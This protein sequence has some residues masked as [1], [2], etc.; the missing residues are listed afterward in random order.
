[1]WT[2]L[3]HACPTCGT[4]YEGS[5]KF[6]AE[7]GTRLGG[8]AAC[9]PARGA[10]GLSTGNPSPTAMSLGEPAAWDARPRAVRSANRSPCCSPTS[11]ASPR[12]SEAR[13]AEEVREQL[14]A[15]FDVASEIDRPVRRHGRE[16]HRRRGDGGLGRPGRAR[17]RRRAGG[18]RRARPGDAV[19]GLEPADASSALAPGVLTGEAAVTARR[20]RTRGWSPATSSTPPRRLQSVAPPGTVLVG[21]ATEQAAASAIVFE[22]VGRAG[23]SRARSAPVPA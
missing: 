16:V 22:P 1:M 23:R 19:Q 13:D 4:P 9:S 20:N 14:T 21:E 2:P 7:C 18:A 12:S 10:N 15:Y 3:A 6:C 17:G 8:A 11:W 5:P